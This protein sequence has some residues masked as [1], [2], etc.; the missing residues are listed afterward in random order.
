V[1]DSRAALGLQ[2]DHAV[3]RPPVD[4]MAVDSVAPW[5]ELPRWAAG[6]QV[7]LVCGIPTQVAILLV[8]RFGFGMPLYEDG[9]L[10]LTFFA[11]LS[12]L[13]TLLVAALIRVFL[14]TTRESAREV[15]V[16]TRSVPGEILRGIALVP[17]VFAVVLTLVLL[18][19]LV[20]PWTHTVEQNPLEA[21]MQTPLD[22]AIFVIVVVLAGGVREELQRAFIL[23]RFEQRLGGVRLGLVLFS[24]VFGAL[25]FEQGADVAIAIGLLG[26]VWGVIYIR[27]RSA[28]LPMANHASFNALQVVQGVLV[29]SLGA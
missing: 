3:E 20:A 22:A 24:L 28:L 29:R 11:T 14:W 2:A 12:L 21:F 9:D 17:V 6:L 5:P 4:L 10:S 25:H 16:G 26:M 23:H 15:F 19:R 13:D 1:D 27:R 7:L 18:L 8:L